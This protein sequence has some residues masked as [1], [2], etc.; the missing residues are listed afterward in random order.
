MKKRCIYITTSGMLSGGPVMAYLKEFNEDPNASILLTGY[1][2]EGTNGRT[3]L[4][5]GYI[6]V[7]GKIF[8]PKCYF[9]KFDLSGHAGHKD[10][11]KLV[12]ILKPK[13]VILNHGD[14][15]SILNFEKELMTKDIQVLAPKINEELE[16]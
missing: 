1:Q 11:L 7:D 5:L 12:D 2:C 3:L 14:E 8:K 9:E 10:L 6:D 15:S 4:E 16:F 13:K